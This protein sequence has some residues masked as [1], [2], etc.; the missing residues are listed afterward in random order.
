ME[1][2]PLSELKTE[3]L[4]EDRTTRRTVTLPVVNSQCRIEGAG[5]TGGRERIVGRQRIATK[6][7]GATDPNLASVDTHPAPAHNRGGRA[8]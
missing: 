5:W 6:D 2:Q 8:T 7:T 1:A 3:F 4:F